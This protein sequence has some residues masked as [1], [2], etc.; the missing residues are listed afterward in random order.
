VA[1]NG[2]ISAVLVRNLVLKGDVEKCFR[3]LTRIGIEGTMAA[4][5]GGKKEIPAH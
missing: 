5:L 3:R 2:A 1:A 4:V